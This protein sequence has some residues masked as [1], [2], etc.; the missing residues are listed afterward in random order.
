M[1]KE[2]TESSPVFQQTALII[3]LCSHIMIRSPKYDYGMHRS[4]NT[5]IFGGGIFFCLPEPPWILL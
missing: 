3:L 4:F 5:Y 1:Q 2:N